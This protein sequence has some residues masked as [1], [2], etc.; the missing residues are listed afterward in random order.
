MDFRE[1]QD[2]W[3]S[4]QAR[5]GLADTFGGKVKREN[6]DT[7]KETGTIKKS[8]DRWI[9]ERRD[10]GMIELANHLDA[11]ITRGQIFKY[12]PDNLP[13]WQT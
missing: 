3:K 2:E 4:F 7:A 1:A 13:P 8:I 6:D 9:R 12:S 11:A 10:A 5:Y